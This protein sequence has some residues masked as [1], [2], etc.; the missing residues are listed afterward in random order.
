MSTRLSIKTCVSAVPRERERQRERQ[1]SKLAISMHI[2]PTPMLTCPNLS[3]RSFP[4]QKFR[5]NYSI[6]LDKERP[7]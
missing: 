5:L 2:K 4:N 3:P 7:T 6:L 1:P